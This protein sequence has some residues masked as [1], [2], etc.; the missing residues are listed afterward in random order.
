MSTPDVARL[1]QLKSAYT[2]RDITTIE[3]HLKFVSARNKQNAA[4]KS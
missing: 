4:L 2:G 1:Q 3:N